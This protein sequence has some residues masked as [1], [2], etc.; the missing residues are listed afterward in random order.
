M[1]TD[2][3]Q[4]QI[5]LKQREVKPTYIRLKILNYL[6]N[7]RRHSDAEQIYRAIKKEIPTISM[8][9][10]YN[11]L[12][13]FQKKN[14]IKPLFITGSEVR[15][16]VNVSPHHHL[17]CEG[18]GKIIDLDVEYE[19]LKKKSIEGHKVIE[20]HGYFKGICKDCLKKQA[21]KKRRKK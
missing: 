2:L 18:C 10:I 19:Y 3:K 7:N 20:V 4:L 17:F 8:T 12:D 13:V 5:R 21:N 15:F 16:D 14:L 11:T 9:S 6:E 1:N